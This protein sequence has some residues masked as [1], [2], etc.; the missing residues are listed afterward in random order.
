MEKTK[1]R[2]KSLGNAHFQKEKQIK[3]KK[4]INQ[5]SEEEQDVHPGLPD[6]HELLRPNLDPLRHA[7]HP[8]LQDIPDHQ[9]I[10]KE[11]CNKFSGQGEL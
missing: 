11:A 6:L 1:M 7:R 2:K 4:I 3:F 9:G 10:G 5:L 8:Q